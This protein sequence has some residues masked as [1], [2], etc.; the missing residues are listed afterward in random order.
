MAV[1]PGAESTRK[2]KA[3]LH[4]SPEIPLSLSV[5]LRDDDPVLCEVVARVAP[6]KPAVSAMIAAILANFRTSPS[7]IFFYSRDRSHYSR[8]ATRRYYPN[9]FTYRAVL[10]AVELLSRNG[11]VDDSRTAP[12]PRALMRSRLRATQPLLELLNGTRTVPVV[13]IENEPI[14]LRRN[15]K[16]KEQIDYVDT[17]EIRAMRADVH[18]QN[19]F[20]RGLTLG[21]AGLTDHEGMVVFEGEQY[22]LS[23]KLFYRV[24]NGS[25]KHGG[26][27]YGPAWQNMP[28]TLRKHLT[29]DSNATCEVDYHACQ[30][31]LLLASGG[32]QLP[33]DDPGFDFYRL[34]GF[35][36]DHVKRAVQILLN[37][38]SRRSALGALIK[39]LANDGATDAVVQAKR[40][41]KAV[42]AAYPQLAPYWGTG[43]GLRLQRIDAD[44]CARVQAELRALGIPVLS[45]HD[46]FVVPFVHRSIL[47]RVMD[48]AMQ[49][50]CVELGRQPLETGG[51]G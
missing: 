44:I 29:I 38:G 37:A 13:Y 33:F 35:D 42:P 39:E 17:D 20:A 24:F 11:F 16:A 49:D 18:A 5:R 21:L 47:K 2:A 1:Q 48:A 9:Y 15:S 4:R 41:I 12:S 46:S 10:A 6:V 19:E 43:I 36:R 45:I 25:F 27:W 34:P 51:M 22:D 28:S 14:V 30:P 31:R 3:R 8:R 40:L 7:T 50:A 23:S 26:R 32:L